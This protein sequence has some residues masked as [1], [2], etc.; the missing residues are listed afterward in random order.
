MI[1]ALLPYTE[2]IQCV[3]A[4]GYIQMRKRANSMI[5]AKRILHIFG[6]GFFLWGK[7]SGIFAAAK[8]ILCFRAY[9]A[10]FFNSLV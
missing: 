10:Y 1:L 6:F 2:H 5:Y 4:I 9:V 7:C 3:V 8:N